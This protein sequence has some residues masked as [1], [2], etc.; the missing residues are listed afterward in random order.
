MGEN[1]FPPEFPTPWSTNEN[2]PTNG[3]PTNNDDI[4]QENQRGNNL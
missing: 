4:P 3:P 1:L 2:G